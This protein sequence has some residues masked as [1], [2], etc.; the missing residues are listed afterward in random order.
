[1]FLMLFGLK[2]QNAKVNPLPN[3]LEDVEHHILI[4]DVSIS[5]LFPLLVIFPFVVLAK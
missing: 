4:L 1:M 5:I 2:Q 3:L